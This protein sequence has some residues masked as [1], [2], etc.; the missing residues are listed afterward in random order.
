MSS[1]SSYSISHVAEYYNS[2]NIESVDKSSVVYE[3]LRFFFFFVTCDTVTWIII[4]ALWC[5]FKVIRS[6]YLCS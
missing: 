4:M 3:I 1:L 6:I 5:G 2:L